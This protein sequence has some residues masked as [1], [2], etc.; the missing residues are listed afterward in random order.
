MLQSVEGPG[1]PNACATPGST[2]SSNGRISPRLVDE[3]VLRLSLNNS[4]VNAS[5]NLS[6]HCRRCTLDRY[7]SAEHRPQI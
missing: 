6:I 5:A 4:I 3:V 2:R 7:G 1:V